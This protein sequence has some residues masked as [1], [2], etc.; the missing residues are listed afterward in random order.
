MPR[1]VFILGTGHCGLPAVV[2]V[3]NRQPGCSVTLEKPPFLP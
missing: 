1:A 3:L 2:D